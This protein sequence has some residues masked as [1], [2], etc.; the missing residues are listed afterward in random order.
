MENAMR[1]ILMTFVL[2]SFVLTSCGTLEIG[3]DVTPLLSH[4]LSNQS[5]KFFLMVDEVDPN[6][7]GAGEVI[8]FSAISYSNGVEETFCPE[9]NVPLIN[10]SKTTLSIVKSIVF[11][12]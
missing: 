3:L 10:N 9:V 1:R 8:S 6:S 2:L 12:P 7:T 11:N 4:L 5:A